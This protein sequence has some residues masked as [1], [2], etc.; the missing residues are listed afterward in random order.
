M[1]RPGNRRVHRTDEFRERLGHM[2]AGR[3]GRRA[4]HC[5]RYRALGIKPLPCLSNRNEFLE[6]VGVLATAAAV[7]L[8]AFQVP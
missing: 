2:V 5:P 1:T 7:G 4:G 6:T 3:C 8:I